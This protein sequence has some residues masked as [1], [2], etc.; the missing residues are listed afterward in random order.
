M[1]PYNTVRLCNWANLT[2]WLIIKTIRVFLCVSMY[3]SIAC[4]RI[5]PC[6][7]CLHGAIAGWW[8]PW[9]S[10]CPSTSWSSMWTLCP[11]VSHLYFILFFIFDYI[12]YT[13]PYFPFPITDGFQTNSLERGT[14][15][16]GTEAFFPC[17]P[18]WWG[19]EVFRPKLPGG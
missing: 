16:G 8:L 17:Y 11:Y 4:L 13:G 15:D 12:S 19:A 6:C 10:P 1:I 18:H 7:A 2:L 9:P 5:S 3:F 14:V